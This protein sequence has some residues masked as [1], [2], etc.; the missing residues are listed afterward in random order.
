MRSAVL[1]LAYG[2]LSGVSG[3]SGISGTSAV[4]LNLGTYRVGWH[5]QTH[6][7]AHHSHRI[8]FWV[9]R[10]R[11]A[12]V[13]EVSIIIRGTRLL[14]WKSRA[15]MRRAMGS[16]RSPT[17]PFAVAG[18]ELWWSFEGTGT[19]TASE[20]VLSAEGH[21]GLIFV[22]LELERETWPVLHKQP[23]IRTR[24][25]L[26]RSAHKLRQARYVL[27]VGMSHE[28][29]ESALSTADELIVGKG[30]VPLYFN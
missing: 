23:C 25:S 18:S 6:N 3:I 21:P 24:G 1:S 15:R 8:Y 2:K 13:G 11:E 26:R 10:W 12:E 5:P 19:C 14:A 9:V 30:V 16:V 7:P 17:P 4:R 27:L 29:V 22:A 28:N 20:S